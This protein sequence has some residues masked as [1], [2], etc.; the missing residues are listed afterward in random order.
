MPCVHRVKRVPTLILEPHKE[1]LHNLLKL[2]VIEE[3]ES[4]GKQIRMCIDFSDLNKHI[5]VNHQLLP[6]SSEALAMLGDA[7]VFGVMDLSSAY[8]LVKFDVLCHAAG[9]LSFYKDSFWFGI[10]RSL[11]SK[12]NEK[13]PRWYSPCIILAG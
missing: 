10:C 6:N 12:G 8:R 9:I 1:E 3:I 2:G 5:W 11:L 4:S 13:G 7:K